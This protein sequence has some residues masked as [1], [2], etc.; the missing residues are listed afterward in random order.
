MVEIHKAM[1]KYPW[2]RPAHLGF[3]NY[4]T[5]FLKI[6]VHRNLIPLLVIL[7]LYYKEIYFMEVRLF[8]GIR[9]DLYVH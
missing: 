8:S 1:G 2:L 7:R 6:N 9:Y 5:L 3:L 4:G